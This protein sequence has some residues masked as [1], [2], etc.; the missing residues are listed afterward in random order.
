MP[1]SLKLTTL[2]HLAGTLCYM[3][4]QWLL[5]III[6]R[7]LGLEAS[8]QYVYFLAILTPTVELL[9]FGLR[10]SLAS[11]VKRRF[12]DGTYYLARSLGMILFLIVGGFAIE[13]SEK[14][15]FLGW[16]VVGLKLIDMTA[17][18]IQA[19][20]IREQTA[21]RYGVS[22]LLSLAMLLPLGLGAILF[23]SDPR[24]L[25]LAYAGARLIS[26]IGYDFRYRGTIDTVHTS[27]VASVIPLIRLSMPLALAA[28][29]AA[30][31]LS[32]P[33]L[34]IENLYDE[35]TLAHY[36]ILIYF[37][38]I[39]LLLPNTITQLLVPRYALL[40]IQRLVSLPM[41]LG[42]IL[43]CAGYGATLSFSLYLIGTPLI[44]IIYGIDYQSEGT[45]FWLLGVLVCVKSLYVIGTMVIAAVR[46]FRVTLAVNLVSIAMLL[47]L[48]GFLTQRWGIQ[49]SLWSE[50]SATLGGLLVILIWG[51]RMHRFK[52][53]QR[54]S[55]S[56]NEPSC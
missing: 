28:L 29:L 6:A 40:G 53:H 41:L 45:E 3:V 1:I 20:W 46:Q 7:Q 15:H 56:L 30:L 21:Y 50:I 49:G 4:S 35:E 26:L 52:H 2:I 55:P 48:C 34:Y 47:V 36:A 12:P 5:L 39:A 33:R 38:L 19:F 11:D 8:G 25:L 37:V 23:C 42:S 13:L 54:T 14:Q 43:L 22:Q 18:L 17:N 10:L 16:L 24:A 51:Y 27:N 32:I 44:E 9:S 31:T